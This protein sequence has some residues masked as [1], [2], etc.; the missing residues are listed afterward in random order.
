M[1]TNTGLRTNERGR[2]SNDATQWRDQDADGIGDNYY[3]PL[4]PVDIEAISGGCLPN[5]SLAVQDTDGDGWGDMYSWIEDLSGSESKRVTHS[6]ST[7]W[8]GQFDGDGCPTDSDR[9]V[10]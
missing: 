2:I 5:Q 6:H 7:H 4:T 3:I 9:T 8:L 10:H 1:D